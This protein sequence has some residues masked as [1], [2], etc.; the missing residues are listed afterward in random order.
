MNDM[1]MQCGAEKE[2]EKKI[3]R[4]N[5]VERRRM[6]KMACFLNGFFSHCHFLGYSSKC[7]HVQAGTLKLKFTR[8]ISVGQSAQI[9]IRS[10]I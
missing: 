4:Y 3:V 1:K 7:V 5:G 2:K 6:R 8:I 9:Y 10:L